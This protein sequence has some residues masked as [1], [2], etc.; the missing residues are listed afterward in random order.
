G[1]SRPA[2][3]VVGTP[4]RVERLREEG[5]DRR[6]DRGLA[7][8]LERLPCRSQQALRL[9]R[10]SGEEPS[11]PGDERARGDPVRVPELLEDC[12]ATSQVLLG[13][14]EVP[15]HGKKDAEVA[16]DVRLDGAMARAELEDLA[17]ANN[18]LGDG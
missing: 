18:S 17:A 16:E 5:G 10:L 13:L 7:H 6:E 4:L 15:F 9:G 12:A 2:L 1:R 8:A 14:D 11:R 3:G